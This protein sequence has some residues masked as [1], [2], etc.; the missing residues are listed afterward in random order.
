M[1]K[2]KKQRADHYDEKVSFAGTF[3]EIIKLSVTQPDKLPEKKA[4][5]KVDKRTNEKKK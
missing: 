1:A 3:E 5:I 2:A 4:A